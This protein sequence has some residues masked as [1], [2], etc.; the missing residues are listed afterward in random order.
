MRWLMIG[1]LISLGSLLLAVAGM[2]RHIRN[3]RRARPGAGPLSLNSPH[4]SDFEAE[5]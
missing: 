5:P 2:A 4:D 1:L 3:H